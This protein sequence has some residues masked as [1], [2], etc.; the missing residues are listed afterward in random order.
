MIRQQPKTKKPAHGLASFA[1]VSLTTLHKLLTYIKNLSGLGLSGLSCG[2][3]ATSANVLTNFTAVFP[4]SS[5]LH[6]RLK[7]PLCLSL[8][9]THILARHRPLA[10]DLTFSH[11]FTLP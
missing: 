6:I 2:L 11:N 3:Q 4:E 9:E 7:L 8:R 5:L 1:N 10:T